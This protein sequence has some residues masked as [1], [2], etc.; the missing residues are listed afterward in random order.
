MQ[1]KDCGFISRIGRHA[2]VSAW[3]L[4]F[5][6]SP[7]LAQ[8]ESENPSQEATFDKSVVQ[9]S[10][11][12]QEYDYTTP[13]KKSAMSRGIGSGFIIEG[14]RILT[15]AHNVSNSRYL[16]V[17]KQNVAKRYPAGVQF[18]GHDCDLAIVTVFDL[19]FYKDMIP[20]EFGPLPQVNST[21]QTCGFPLGG[22]T[23]SVTEGVV[24]RIEVGTYSHTQADSHLLVQT[25]AAI[26]PGNSG[27]PVLQN[28]KVVGVAF[29]GIQAAENIGFMIP[30][31]VIHHFLE[32]IKDGKYDGFGS[33][34][35]FTFEGLHNPSY[36]QYLKIPE[37]TEG[38]IV[39][40]TILNSSV[41]TILA[42]NDVITKIGDFDIDNDGMIRIYGLMLD[43]SEAVEQKQI[44]QAIDL[45]FYRNGEKH[46][47]SVKV[48]YNEPVLTFRR[49]FD[50]PPR[51]KCFAGMTFV[52]LNRNY[53]ETW[54]RNWISDIPFYLRYLFYDV[55]NLNT[56]PLRKEYVV[57]SEILPDELTTYVS[58]FVRQPVE[59]VNGVPIMSI[60]DLDAAFAQ[61]LDGFWIIRFLGN[62]TPMI[63][64][65]EKARQR[66]QEILEKHEVPFVPLPENKI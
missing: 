65:A 36:A 50:L 15:N 22:R 2:P 12:Q 7:L 19:D 8:T 13:W 18:V 23:V 5:L 57:L 48:D 1:K 45:V 52:T 55:Q 38:V 24:S 47:A 9:L 27:G 53:L 28:G 56:D 60:E 11:V 16:E 40:G 63:V 44:G 35:V 3:M 30:T 20:L 25:D 37:G 6:L 64:D 58:G 51:Y 61:D 4:F 59:S 26:N 42:K 46:T 54:G 49:E 39:L 10:I 21:V 66:H 33:L 14:N 17:K 43:M 41:E 31:P 34:G 29:Q 32:D 62:N